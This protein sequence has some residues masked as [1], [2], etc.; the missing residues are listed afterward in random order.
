MKLTKMYRKSS[1]K[2]GYDINV[3]YEGVPLDTTTMSAADYAI[4][5][6]TQNLS[7]EFFVVKSKGPD[8][9][10]YGIGS[11]M[12]F[13]SGRKV[14]PRTAY[15][16]YILYRNG[17]VT[18]KKDGQYNRLVEFFIAQRELEA[19]T[20]HNDGSINA[21][22]QNDLLLLQ[23]LKNIHVLRDILRGSI[24]N[25]KALIKAYMKDSWDVADFTYADIEDSFRIIA[26]NGLSLA[27][28]RDYT[29]SL[30]GTLHMLAQYGD[31]HNGQGYF[32]EAN[33]ELQ[34]F[35]D[36]LGDA[37]I[38]DK[39]INPK[40]SKTRMMQEHQ[41]NIKRILKKEL[42][43]QDGTSI[44]DKAVRKEYEG[45]VFTAIDS[46]RAALAESKTMENCFFYNYWQNC[47]QR[48]YAG[49][50]ITSPEGENHK[51]GQQS[52]HHVRPDP[53][54][55]QRVGRRKGQEDS[56]LVP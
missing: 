40:W 37:V 1:R 18:V 9:V 49:F 29:T 26:D 15:Y 5:A 16:S 11:E 43:A 52:R 56:P 7:R 28:L 46:P 3:Y 13:R 34:L 39:R 54:L 41:D 55:P 31:A 22:R 50:H 48:R 36:P 51:E 35:R 6:K 10:Y 4:A 25:R 24:T 33:N 45:Y 14:F 23:A 53:H 42:D 38:L 12:L 47:V 32:C 27:D 44:Y 19:L 17:R 8:D 21:D 20:R 30:S 2:D